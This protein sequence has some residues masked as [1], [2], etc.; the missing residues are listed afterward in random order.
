MVATTGAVEPQS[1][2]SSVT[3]LWNSSSRMPRGISR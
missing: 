1:E 2:S 3:V